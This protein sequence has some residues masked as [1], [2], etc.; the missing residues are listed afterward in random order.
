MLSKIKRWFRFRRHDDAYATTTQAIKLAVLEAL[1]VQVSLGKTVWLVT[2]FTDTFLDYQN[3]LAEAGFDYQ[4]AN[5]ELH[6]RFLQ[7][8]G[9]ANLTAGQVTLVLSAL[10]P[11]VDD[12]PSR[13]IDRKLAVMVVERHPLIEHDQRI[14]EFCKLLGAPVELGYFQSFED[15]IVAAELNEMTVVLMEQMGLKDHNLINS[16]T[17]TRRI[18]RKLKR[19]RYSTDLVADNLQQWFQLNASE[20]D[21]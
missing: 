4:I 3:L 8:E 18:D 11:K 7:D 17:L 9:D 19:S 15:P 16:M 5:Q 2:H 6:P 10:I 1:G 21:R 13:F 12:L 20:G 14:H